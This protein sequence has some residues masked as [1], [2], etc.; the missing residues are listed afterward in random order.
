MFMFLAGLVAGI[1]LTVLAFA[2]WIGGEPPTP[3]PEPPF[4]PR[5]Y[6]RYSVTPKSARG[7]WTR[8]S[9]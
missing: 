7:R 5:P 1:M 6:D 4:P 2:W 3:I 8:A 9:R